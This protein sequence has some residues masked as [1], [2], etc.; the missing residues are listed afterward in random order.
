MLPVAWETNPGNEWC[1]P[2]HGDLYADPAT[3]KSIKNS[4]VYIY[5]KAGKEAASQRYGWYTKVPSGIALRMRASADIAP[6][7]SSDHSAGLRQTAKIAN[8]AD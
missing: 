7:N 1:P 6:T 8:V 5:P 3:P 4:R 2:G